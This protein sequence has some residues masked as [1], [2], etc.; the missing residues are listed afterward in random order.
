MLFLKIEFF[1][2]HIHFDCVTDVCSV[3]HQLSHLSTRKAREVAVF[4]AATLRLLKSTHSIL[5]IVLLILLS[6]HV[7][8]KIQMDE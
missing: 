4:G 2:V 5:L 7:V 1:F 8:S 6:E 3:F